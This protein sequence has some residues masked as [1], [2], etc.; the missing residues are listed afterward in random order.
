MTVLTLPATLTQVQAPEVL[1]RLGTAARAAD[2][3]VTVDAG[4]LAR[5]DSSALAVLLDLRRDAGRAG[6]GFAIQGMPAPL[7]NLAHLYGV[8]ELLG[9]DAIEG[10]P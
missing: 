7:A 1:G 9:V 4:A 3:G 10:K 8:D 5:F 2:G 6:R